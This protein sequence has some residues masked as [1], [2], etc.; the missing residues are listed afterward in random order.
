M[1]EQLTLYLPDVPGKFTD[2]V[3]GLGGAGVNILGFNIGSRDGFNE[4]RLV[5]YPLDRAKETLQRKA[6]GCTNEQV[7]AVSVP[8]EP[9]PLLRITELMDANGIRILYGYSST[10]RPKSRPN[11]AVVIVDTRNNDRAKEILEKNGCVD[12][13]EYAVQ[14]L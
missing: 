9:N 14:H 5:C 4:V 10:I 8:D 7:L 13:D 11:D 3:K 12:L 6:Y 1:L 2:V